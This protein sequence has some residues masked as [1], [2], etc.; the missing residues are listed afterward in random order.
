[1]PDESPCPHIAGLTAITPP[2][3]HECD[4]CVKIGASWVHLRTCQTCGGTHCCDSSP[5]RHAT[6][7]AHATG[8]PVVASAEPGER[9]VYCYPD[10]AFAEY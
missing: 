2:R 6:A 3:R 1:M 8:H 7:H 9:W 4:E 10:E 5:N